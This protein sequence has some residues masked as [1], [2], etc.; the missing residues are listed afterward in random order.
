[1]VACCGN[2][3]SHLKLSNTHYH[4]S[5]CLS[6]YRRL[7]EALSHLRKAKHILDINQYQR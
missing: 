2:N 7:P 1:M 5:E 4:I 6:H 3:Q